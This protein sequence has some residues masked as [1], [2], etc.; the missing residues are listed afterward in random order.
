MNSND[1]QPSKRCSAILTDS[2]SF[3]RTVYFCILNYFGPTGQISIDWVI[4]RMQSTFPEPLCRFF[5][6][7]N[8]FNHGK[9]SIRVE[10]ASE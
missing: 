1:S 7:L 10:R 5:P 3:Q 6:L 4:K 2:E 9:F 8:K